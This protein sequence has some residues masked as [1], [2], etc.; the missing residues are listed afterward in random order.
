MSDTVALLFG[1]A[2]I[3][4]Y[5]FDRFNRAS[6]EGGR[7][8]QRLMDLLT[9]DKLRARRVVFTAFLLYASALL[10]VYFFLCAYAEVLPILGGPDLSSASSNASE[11]Q[12][13]GI[14]PSISLS[15]ALIIV[16]LAPTFPV[17]RR[18]E[19]QI[20]K[21]AHQ[22]AGIP[23][24]VTSICEELSH[25]RL[26]IL[27]SWTK[28]EPNLSKS[29]PDEYLLIPSTDWERMAHYMARANENLSA[30]DDFKRDLEI[31]FAIS[32][33]ILD[34]SLKLPNIGVRRRFDL[35]EGE[36]SKRVDAFKTK[37]DDKSGFRPGNSHQPVNAPDGPGD[38]DAQDTE[39]ERRR[40]SW[41]QLAIEADELADDL[42]VLLALLVEHRIIT[43]ERPRKSS[44]GTHRRLARQQGVAQ[45][46]LTD[47]LGM[48]ILSGQD[49]AVNSRVSPV[50]VWFWSVGTVAMIAAL[51]AIF[52]GGFEDRMQGTAGETVYWR[53]VRYVATSFNSYCIPLAVA[54]AIRSGAQ[55]TENWSRLNKAPLTKLAPQA[56]FV[57]LL[58]WSLAAIFFV[59][60]ALWLAALTGTGFTS[61]GL[62]VWD[63]LQQLFEFNAPTPVRGAILALIVLLLLDKRDVA[64][65]DDNA[66]K[67][68]KP[69]PQPVPTST[70][71]AN[72]AWG[73]L[74]GGVLL[75]VGGASRALA[76]WASMVHSGRQA[77]DDIDRGL[78][79]YAS[80]QSAIVGFAV[81]FFVAQVVSDQLRSGQQERAG[82]SG[83]AVA[84][85]AQTSEG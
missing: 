21:A 52:P 51:W 15:I 71:R 58:S 55:Q 35:L 79:V 20:R 47:F 49:I 50:L 26:D 23:G 83:N 38:A 34:R 13:I 16:G 59:G 63:H 46:R 24:H 84:P 60:V 37:L 32:R 65:Q 73:A 74:A 62:G 54:L 45:Q 72:L 76:S 75:V 2:I 48:D 27:A 12:G 28:S 29:G 66:K 7:Q 6:Y 43:D 77:L 70:L 82:K 18:F 30:P 14:E 69:S 44:E 17:L 81:L 41:E 42:C 53:I 57:V 5:S 8:L 9:P 64:N 68:E 40:A 80:L 11:R 4:V 25:H 33:W 19:D 61:S 67:T 22:F 31:V 85:A 36:L 10:I 39:D 3:L 56:T 1:A 78:I